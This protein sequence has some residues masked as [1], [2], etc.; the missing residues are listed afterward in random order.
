MTTS[1]G[2][3]T[4]HILDI[5]L[6]G[7]SVGEYSFTD[8]EREL[9]L[10][11]KI[12]A[13]KIFYDYIDGPIDP[14]SEDNII[15]VMTGPLTG[16]GAPSSSRF[17]ISTVSPL[18]GLLASSNCGGSF[19]LFLK[20]SGYDGIIIRGKSEVPIHVDISERNVSFLD[21]SQLWGKTTGDTQS[22]IGG[23]S[24]KIV[25]GPAGENLVKYAGVFSEE[26]TAGRA[27][28]G[29]VMGSK[30]LKAVTAQGSVLLDIKDREK[31]KEINK[32]WVKHLKSHPI[33]GVQLPKLGTAGL[34][35]AMNVRHML[36][37]R[38]YRYGKF[39]KYDSISGETMAE[40]YLVKNKGCITCPI[41][42]SRVVNID[43]K[44]VKGPEVETL[45]L[46][47]SNLEN[48]DLESILRWNYELDELGMDTITMGSTIGFAME[49]NERG[50]WDN[51][52]HFGC[53]DN[54]SEVM[55]DTAYR[56]GIGNLLA[57]GTR[58][59]AK[60][61]GASDCAMNVKGLE[62]A[63][64]EPRGAVGQGLGYAVAN[65]GGCHLNGGYL[66]ALEGLGLS[67][68]PYTKHG[69]AELCSMFQDLMEAVSAG[70]NC[71]FT[72]YAMLPGFLIENPNSLISRWTNKLLPHCGPILRIA[73]RFATPLLNVNIPGIFP[74]S[75]AVKAAT[76]MNMTLGRYKRIGERGYN[77]ERLINMRLGMK[78]SDDR[79]PS[80][81]TDENQID[82]DSRTK[83]PI[84]DM[85]A[86]Y[87]RV[88]GWTADGVPSGSLLKRLG[89]EDGRHD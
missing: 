22:S 12:A 70:G 33:T 76:G 69:K 16:T 68:D 72:T 63:A 38:N 89:I 27:G 66:V 80:R 56:H 11:G 82:G 5:N 85:K 32:N 58:F 10:G 29:A 26:R 39:A 36:A 84:A 46:L 52:L 28:V 81:L 18:T 20:K 15:V 61:F 64:Y 40:K 65:R 6:T 41:Q 3:Y 4:G 77:L 13:A 67:I 60:R 42:C 7:R 8:D 55:R 45:G 87:Y 49:L 88:R 25:I 17:N 78:S 43:G 59:L 54:I 73:N 50:L 83:V 51:G 1:L 31:T 53:T 30:K 79:L 21:A 24:G 71:I 47:G 62:L 44:A 57:E 35:S 9:Y 14:L 74:Y 86:E 48:N 75:S 19:G 34:L 2:G 37:T 23:R